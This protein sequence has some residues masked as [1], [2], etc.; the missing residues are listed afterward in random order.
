[1]KSD[2]RLLKDTFGLDVDTIDIINKAV[3]K[4]LWQTNLSTKIKITN[5]RVYKNY[6]PTFSNLKFR[7][8]CNSD[9]FQRFKSVVEML[10]H[11]FRD[12]PEARSIKESLSSITFGPYGR[13]RIRPR[14][15]DFIK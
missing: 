2:I 3:L 6:I 9:V 10:E 4:S 14:I 15:R 5:L 1:M 11:A 8:V 13:D 7:W 12:F